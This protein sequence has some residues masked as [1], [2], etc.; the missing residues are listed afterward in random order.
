MAVGDRYFREGITDHLIAQALIKRHNIGS[1][2]EDHEFETQIAGELLAKGHELLAKPLT[3]TLGRNR[4]L[5]HLDRVV[6]LRRENEASDKGRALESHEMIVVCLAVKLTG[7][8]VQSKRQ[9][10]HLLS[11]LN[12]EFVFMAT[13]GDI[14][15]HSDIGHRYDT[16]EVTMLIRLF[17][18]TTALSIAA[19][20]LAQNTLSYTEVL[21]GKLPATLKANEIPDGFKACRIKVAGT[22]TNPI[23]DMM[24]PML[25]MM[26]GLSTA[27]GSAGDRKPPGILSVM[28]V[29]WTK[30]DIVT[31]GGGEF[32]VTYSLSMEIWDLASLGD[33]KNV[34]VPELKL[35]LIRT[36]AINSMQPLVAMTRES[37]A[38]ALADRGSPSTAIEVSSSS[39]EDEAAVASASDANDRLSR[40]KQLALGCMMYSSDYDDVYPWAQSSKGWFTVIQPYVKN[41]ELIYT[42]NPNAS[43]NS[44]T[45]RFNLNIGGVNVS[46]IED[47]ANAVLL[48]DPVPDENG[49]RV[50]AFA[51]GH[52]KKIAIEGWPAIEKALQRKYKRSATKP[53][54]ANLGAGG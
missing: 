39:G 2:I 21:S 27:F 8:E 12:R 30:G 43:P 52:A 19:F 44:N 9:T 37:F 17:A 33:P 6:G 51:D 16:H 34:T 48:F 29:A 20:G 26:G 22:S 50:V 11:Q 36:S 14:L 35:N 10:E 4:Y 54:P 3:L 23:S 18:C 25:M 47:P 41:N 13:K 42:H 28:D 45:F 5:A 46:M 40:A 7:C 31:V 38:A 32:M 24:S 53:L 49:L 15:A 1:G